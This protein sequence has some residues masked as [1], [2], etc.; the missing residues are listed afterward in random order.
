MTEKELKINSP[1]GYLHLDDLPDN[2][3]FN[4]AY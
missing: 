2:C 4:K 1:D 3:I